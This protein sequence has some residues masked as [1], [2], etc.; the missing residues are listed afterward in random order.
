[1]LRQFDAKYL[2]VVSILIGSYNL[3]VIIKINLNSFG[4]ELTL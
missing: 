1:M 4:L 2:V 3:W